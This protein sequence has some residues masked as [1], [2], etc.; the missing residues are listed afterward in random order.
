MSTALVTGA[1]AGIGNA[2]ARRLATDGHDVVVVARDGERLER[3]AADI[4]A[5][6][7]GAEVLVADLADRDQLLTVEQRLADPERPVDLLVNNAGY[8]VNQSFVHGDVD[9]EELMLDV[10]VRAVLR[11]SHAAAGPMVERRRGA[12]VNVSSVASFLPFGTYSAAKS[13][14]TAFSQGLANEVEES[15]VRVMALCPGFVHT[16]FHER[17]G[18]DLSGS[19]EW[20]WL[21]ADRLV[22][23][24]MADLARGKVISVPGRQYKA[25]AAG[26]HLVPRDAV[27]RLEKARRRV[28]GGRR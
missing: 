2:F 17:A 26:T 10:L 11:L 8:T 6:G 24:A 12:I 9:A 23:D 19:R 22:A 21:D 15:G 16:E 18:I 13:W 4:R 14:V 25:L 7:V 3:V 1:T 5:R 20:M 28:L 27:R